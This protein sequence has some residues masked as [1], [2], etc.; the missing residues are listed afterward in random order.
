MRSEVLKTLAIG[1]LLVDLALQVLTPLLPTVHA[2]PSVQGYRFF[3]SKSYAI[4]PLGTFY[5]YLAGYRYGSIGA[6][7]IAI[8]MYTSEA[9][10]LGFAESFGIDIDN[11]RFWKTESHFM[12]ADSRLILVW[13]RE[14]GHVGRYAHDNLRGATVLPTGYLVAWS[15][16]AVAVARAPGFTYGYH[17][18]VWEGVYKR[19]VEMLLAPEEALWYEGYI[20]D[21]VR[22]SIESE[23][24]SIVAE[25]NG[26]VVEGPTIVFSYDL[27]ARTVDEARA[28]LL[29]NIVSA[30]YVND[31]VYV[32]AN[33]DLIVSAAGRVVYEVETEG[34][35][36]TREAV[37]FQILPVR[38]GILARVSGDPESPDVE[39]LEMYDEVVAGVTTSAMCYV[40]K[41]PIRESLKLKK[42]V[43]ITAT[44]DVYRA[45]LYTEGAVTD[46]RLV[47]TYAFVLTENSILLVFNRD[48]YV[49]S[50]V[51]A[52]IV[53]AG[54]TEE[55]LVYLV[56]RNTAG[57]LELGV[58]D[59][60]SGR[61][62]K[63]T[64]ETA[65]RPVGAHFAADLL[66]LAVESPEAGALVEIGTRKELATLEILVVDAYG[67][68]VPLVLGREVRVRY[69]RLVFG[70]QV[71]G[72]PIILATPTPAHVEGE[73]EV[74][75]WRG[76]FHYELLEPGIYSYRVAAQ[77]PLTP[78]A[79]D[80][81]NVSTLFYNPFFRDYVIV[82]DAELVKHV[83]PGARA[84]DAYGTLLALVEASNSSTVS[85]LHV[86]RV[87]GAKLYTKALPGLVTEVKFFYPYLVAKEI[88]NIY[89]LD[90]LSGVLKGALTLPATGY[91]LDVESEYLSAWT[92][93]SVALL[94][95]RRQVPYYLDLSR[96][97][98]VVAAPVVSGAI[99]AYIVAEEGKLNVYIISPESRGIVDVLPWNGEEVEGLV[100][101]GRFHVV[102][103]RSGGRRY[104]DVLSSANGIVTVPDGPAKC[105]KTLGKAVNMPQ[106]SLLYGNLFAALAVVDDGVGRVYVVGINYQLI[107]ELRGMPFRDIKFTTLFLAEAV[108][109]GNETSPVIVLRDYG[110]IPRLTIVLSKQPVV[111]AVSEHLVAYGDASEVYMISNPRAV[112]KYRV[113][114]KIVDDRLQPIDAQV[115]I[116]EFGIEAT[117]KRGEFTAYVSMPGTYRIEVSAP[118]F[119]TE[120]LE[121]SL[122]DKTP[123][124]SEYVKL[125]P[126]KYR[127]TV[128]VLTADG[129]PAG[130]GVVRV[131]GLTE[132]F[133][134]DVDISKENTV[135]VK[136]GVY[137]FTYMS[138]VYKES[139]VEMNI[140]R[141]EVV[142]IVTE[143][144]GVRLRV[145][146]VDEAG[147][148]LS[149]VKVVVESEDL[150]TPIEL[151]SSEVGEVTVVIP[152]NITFSVTASAPGRSPARV[153]GVAA[154]EEIEREPIV[155]TLVKVRGTIMILLQDEMGT[156]EMGTVT[157]RDAYG[158]IVRVLD[159]VGSAAVD[160]DLGT[161]SIEAV[162]P[163]GRTASAVV[164]LTE[165]SPA[166][167]ATLV[168]P[169]KRPPVY[170]EIY[171]YLV[172][173]A[174]AVTAVVI[175]YRRFFRKAKPKRVEVT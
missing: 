92:S 72:N 91:V 60:Y 139:V 31:A 44:G 45:T 9:Q 28:K 121:V 27:G 73:V 30:I 66:F 147:A 151:V 15:P 78:G 150:P 164:V 175:V 157:V 129:K 128:H 143:R 53:D 12:L 97:G 71:A 19:F 89:V 113:A 95:L 130:E 76:S 10:T 51:A 112:G 167:A 6:E 74:P 107:G 58:F 77:H 1:L 141:D 123:S 2:L 154:T 79:L 23:L 108:M 16:T 3:T 43:I 52:E 64:V 102:S 103:Y 168:V 87:D 146:T 67:N 135:H 11:L 163:D 80:V 7:L 118:H 56:Y 70:V 61:V 131:E 119:E 148:P 172:I 133:A 170:V 47:D 166:G 93:S 169:G 145:R 25:D 125:E 142:A 69:G 114:L 136:V 162:T 8:D 33:V 41:P 29:V 137:R 149:G 21:K 155:L 17:Y 173:V 37:T 138:D 13:D 117:A 94:D 83:L 65:Y 39:F 109:G 63:F 105:V 75:Y 57:A 46:L 35:T 81:S 84:L 100:S 85:T 36:E 99:Y 42:M 50:M 159:V 90:A 160:V 134:T 49:M 86:F 171:P 5:E 54:K 68:P 48:R 152:Y 122:T 165:E 140:T 101:D 132:P 127:V 158:N 20:P 106:Q 82:S 120:L 124:V 34:G 40:Y 111:F 161:Y 59:I 104:M 38:L 32:V 62:D 26:I 110:G 153:E 98:R 96:Y 156:T 22:A 88:S 24:L 116:K 144:T 14:I 174:I 18:D 4:Y 115:V 126:K 55:G